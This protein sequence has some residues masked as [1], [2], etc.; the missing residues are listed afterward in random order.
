MTEALAAE[1]AA[2]QEA[3]ALKAGQKPKPKL[4]PPGP[5][6]SQG[7]GPCPEGPTGPV[8]DR[9]ISVSEML[10]QIR[11]ELKALKAQV[12]FDPHLRARAAYHAYGEVL[13]FKNSQGNRMPDWKDLSE[14]KQKAWIAA[15]NATA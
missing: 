9:G 8:G 6:F 15:A 14:G 11:D 7:P 13:N 2:G 3:L 12:N 5:T 10:G 1:I 4:E